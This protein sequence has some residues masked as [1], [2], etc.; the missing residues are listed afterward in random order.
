MTGE[1]FISYRRS[2]QDKARLLDAVL[3]QRG[4]GGDDPI[5]QTLQAGFT[6]AW[7]ESPGARAP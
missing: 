7:D 6:K 4:A 2:D 3:K 5:A 1:I